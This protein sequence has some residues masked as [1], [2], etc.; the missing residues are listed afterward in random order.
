MT[1][2]LNG[3]KWTMGQYLRP[4]PIKQFMQTAPDGATVALS[5]LYQNPY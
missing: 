3:Y 5:P 2:L 1:D 4:L